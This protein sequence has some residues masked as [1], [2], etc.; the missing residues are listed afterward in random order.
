MT[1]YSP[2]QRRRILVA[3]IVASSMGFIDGSVISIVTPAIR[4]SLGASLA[5]V[6]WVSNA[7]LLT[8]SS[9]LLLGGAT[10][11]RYGL[12]NVFAAGIVLFVLASIASA[13]A[14]NASLLIAARAV[15]GI[16]AAFMVPGSLA[17]IAE[18]YPKEQRG[19]AIGTW[20]AASSLTT[21]LGPVLGGALLTWFGNDSWRWVFAINLPLGALALVLLIGIPTRTNL[22]RK[23]L[24][25]AGAALATVTLLLISWAFIDASGWFWAYLGAGLAMLAVFIFWE[26]RATAPMLP[27]NLFADPRFSGA[28]AVTFLI[29][30]GLSAVLFYLPMVMIAGWRISPAEVAIALLP[31]GIVL[32]VLSAP[33]GKLT[34]WLGPGPVIATGALLVTLCFIGLG[35]TAHLH[36]VWLGI[37]PLMTLFGIGV[38]GIAGPISTAVMGAVA[39]GETGTASAINNAVARVAGLVA[40]AA[41]G[42]LALFVFNLSA[43]A[44]TAFGVAPDV[45]A[46]GEAEAL[47]VAA[48]D[49]AFASICYVTA[50]LAAVG[51]VLS[52]KTIGRHRQVEAAK[53]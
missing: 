41:M 45:A 46:S 10:G 5:D 49:R 25:F 53:N 13:I 48:T 27:L 8:L 39:D 21:L 14:G 17:I 35:L 11:D 24:D 30:F 43:P 29:Y 12:R 31:F 22:A 4:A 26:A 3:A 52:W 7:Y 38:S 51:A 37:V 15:Q 6:Q 36:Q 9:L 20:A 47:R 23:P 50:A 42:G 16:G 2:A 18:A 33:A 44:I 19:G 28:Q 34:D 1:D 32:T 40:I